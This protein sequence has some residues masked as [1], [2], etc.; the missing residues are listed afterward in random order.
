MAHAEKLLGVTNLWDP[1]NMDVLHHVN[2]GLRAHTLFQRDVDY[3]VQGRPGRDRRRV[4]RAASCRAGAGRTA[5][6]RRSRPR[7]R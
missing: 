7:R 6:T 2:Q 5:S 1:S 4:H 3:V